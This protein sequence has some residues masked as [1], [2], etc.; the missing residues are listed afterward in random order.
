[1]VWTDGHRAA[2]WR[3][4][5]GTIEEYWSWAGCALYLLLSVDLL[6][7]VNAVSLYGTGVEANPHMRWLLSH[8]LAVV[9]AVHL[10][11]LVVVVILL[12]SYFRLLR[13]TEGVTAWV[14][15]KSFELWV[16]LLIAAGLFVFA[17]NLTAIV[18]GA[19]LL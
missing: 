18:L 11:A 5:P 13:R 1:M 4:D 9:V 8:D 16:A 10:L 3:V 19:S 12:A 15:A 17:N 2:D 6:V 14:M 7:T